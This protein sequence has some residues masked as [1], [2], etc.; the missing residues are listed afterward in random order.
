MRLGAAIAIGVGGM[1]GGGIFGVLGVVAE[2]AGGGATVSFA[3]AGGLA[4]LTAAS[5]SRLSVA[6]PNRGGTIVFLNRA[7]GSSWRTGAVNNLMWGGYVVALALYA[8]A[9]ADYTAALVHGGSPPP[10]LLLHG[11][12]TAAIVVPMLVNLLG[13]GAVGRAETAIV[14][15]K[16]V[17]LGVVVIAGAFSVDAD[18]LAPRHWPSLPAVV[19]AGMLIFIAYEGFELI[20]NAAEDLDRPRRNLPR[21]FFASVSIVVVLYVAIAAVTVGT[22]S[23]SEITRSADY[24]LA[25]ASRS[26]L[27]QLG[28]TLVATSAVLATLSAINATLYGAS[29]LSYSIAVEGEL[30]R[31]FARR[32]WD[33]PVGLLVTTVGA[34]ALANT[35]DLTSI[36]ALASVVFLVVFALVNAA[37]LKLARQIGSNRSDCGPG[38]CWMCCRGHLPRGRHGPTP[39]GCA[40]PGGQP[41]C[42]RPHSSRFS[43]C[44]DSGA[45]AAHSTS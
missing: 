18:R 2:Q 12:V 9:F 24:A 7:F 34:V 17:I 11:L 6:Y 45:G 31:V 29:Q 27:G 30:P 14:V 15:V 10:P 36:A 13:A 19:G 20:A 16:V 5:Y 37:S 4:L 23:P 40:G 41:R 1:V 21:A 8:R 44:V 26:S 39:P 28:F 3:V 32:A 33:Q 35:V 42:S 25:E 43:G 22:L 38:R